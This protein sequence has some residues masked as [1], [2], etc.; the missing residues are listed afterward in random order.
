MGESDNNDGGTDDSPVSLTAAEQRNASP[1]R[2]L[3]FS[4]GVFAIIITI[5]VLD[6]KVPELDSGVALSDSLTDMRPSFIAFVLSFLLVGMYWVEHRG[7]FTQI[8][9]VDA[10][11]LWLNLVFL[12]P[13]S[14][15]PFAASALGKYESNPTALHLYGAVLMAATLMRLILV[16]YLQRHPGLSWVSSTKQANRLMTVVGIAP[17]VVYGAAMLVASWQPWLSVALYLS[18][19]LLYFGAI[20]FLKTDPRTRVDAEDLA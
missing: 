5:L 3:F 13:L 12:L 18:M 2:M 4:D 16:S 20:A 8:R 11:V 14:M 6:L 10:N 1:E 15:V 19:P 17:M 7:M 9:Y